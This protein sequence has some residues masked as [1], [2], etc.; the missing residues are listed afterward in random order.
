MI[1]RRGKLAVFAVTSWFAL[2]GL[3]ERTV[4][5][6]FFT[7]QTSAFAPCGAT[8]APNYQGIIRIVLPRRLT[9]SGIDRSVRTARDL[10]A[11]PDSDG[12]NDSA[13]TENDVHPGDNDEPYHIYFRKG[14]FKPNTT[15]VLVRVIIRNRSDYS[16]WVQ[17]KQTTDPNERIIKGV[18]A[19]GP[20]PDKILCGMRDIKTPNGTG[21]KKQVASFLINVANIKTTTTAPIPF[22]IAVV[23]DD[24]PDTP[25][26]IDPKVYNDG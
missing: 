25:I 26:F 5:P 23:S 19:A 22:N 1:K 18:G 9:F 3:A 13:G 17:P 11:N 20:D 2:T 24:Y 16:F 21:A 14:D 8:D 7:P 15:F 6:F 12:K 10:P 4:A